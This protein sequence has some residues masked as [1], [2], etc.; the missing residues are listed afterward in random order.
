[1]Q[2]YNFD[3]NNLIKFALKSI[4]L[5]QNILFDFYKDYLDKQNYFYIDESNIIIIK[6]G[7][8]FLGVSYEFNQDVVLGIKINNII[9]NEIESE[10]NIINFYDTINLLKNDIINFE[11]LSSYDINIKNF[12]IIN[13]NFIKLIKF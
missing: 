10:N 12:S 2:K 6:D 7:N 4:T 9:I 8:Y 11:N 5:H 3:S 13:N 1:M